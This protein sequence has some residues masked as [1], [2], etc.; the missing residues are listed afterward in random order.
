MISKR[1][2]ILPPKKW[3]PLLVVALVGLSACQEV[4]CIKGQGSV[5][6]RQLE[7]PPIQE[8]EVNGNFRV[9]L[10]QAPAQHQQSIEVR[11]EP[12][13]LNEL[14]TEVVN[15]R[16]RIEFRNCVRRHERVEVHINLHELRA[17]SLNGSGTIMFQ[18]KINASTVNVQQN[19]SGTIYLDLAANKLITNKSG[20]G[21]LM[22]VGTVEEHHLNM[23]GSGKVSLF[24][25]QTD[26]SHVNLTGS[27]TAE[28]AVGRTLHVTI[29]GSGSV[30]YTGSPTL[31]STSIRGSGKVVKK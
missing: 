9:N 17:V 4:T 22:G 2:Q 14:R 5:E 20:S 16:W 23:A 13:I 31:S 30:F 1:P 8:V 6:N 3:L 19:G 7:L 25:L 29:D 21:E 11:G 18:N 27:G 15:G 10:V 24:N 28:I 26:D 12:N